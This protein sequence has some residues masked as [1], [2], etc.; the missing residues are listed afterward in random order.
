MCHC[1]IGCAA[2]TTTT[3]IVMYTTRF[4]CKHSVSTRVGRVKTVRAV[5]TPDDVDGGRRQRTGN[6]VSITSRDH[7]LIDVSYRS[8][9]VACIPH[10]C[11]PTSVHV[12]Y[13]FQTPLS[14]CTR[15][16]SMN[17]PPTRNS[18][19]SCGRGG[20]CPGRKR[21]GICTSRR[22]SNCNET[23]EARAQIDIYYNNDLCRP[24]SARYSWFW[25]RLIGDSRIQ[26]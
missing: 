11:C 21:S 17:G 9:V 20:Q 24:R 22:I 2:A 3:R 7:L 1:V 14:P 6:P 15:C 5:Y 18:C 26:T 8:V 4:K 12:R 19:N 16:K 23:E 13:R 10:V 25:I